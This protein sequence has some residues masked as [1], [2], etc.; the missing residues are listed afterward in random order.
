MSSSF[1]G[2]PGP[3]KVCRRA[4]RVLMLSTVHPAAGNS[5]IALLRRTAAM[6]GE[7][8]GREMWRLGKNT[9]LPRGSPHFSVMFQNLKTR[10]DRLNWTSPLSMPHCTPSMITTFSFSEI[11]HV[12]LTPPPYKSPC[13]RPSFL[14]NYSV[15]EL[16]WRH[17][18]DS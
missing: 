17:D 2:V 13:L 8:M 18:D 15:C 11:Q 12:V 4:H 14:S 3:Q 16:A 9:G 5:S 7:P 6:H 1:P 10:V